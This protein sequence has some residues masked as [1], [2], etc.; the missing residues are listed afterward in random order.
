MGAEASAFNGTAAYDASLTGTVNS[1]LR[2]WIKL[3]WAQPCYN[4]VSW[5]FKILGPAGNVNLTNFALN[6]TEIP[7]VSQTKFPF[8]YEGEDT[9]FFGSQNNSSHPASIQSIQLK[10]AFAKLFLL[11]IQMR[12]AMRTTANG[13]P[14]VKLKFREKVSFI[15]LCIPVRAS[16]LLIGYL[17]TMIESVASLYTL[18]GFYVIVDV[19]LMQQTH[20]RSKNVIR[21]GDNYITRYGLISSFECS[22]ICTRARYCW[23][24]L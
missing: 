3:N 22:Y 14:P 16:T 17:T 8:D 19:I 2:A 7:V 24:G 1:L 10:L 13:C 23:S 12:I 18:Y 9:R 6:T 5:L 4:L 21:Y 15:F 20:E 11:H